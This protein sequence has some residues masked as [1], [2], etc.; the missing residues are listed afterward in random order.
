MKIMINQLV[1]N[2]APVVLLR[3]CMRNWLIVIDK[4]NIALK[5]SFKWIKKI[6]YKQAGL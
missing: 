2:Y 1:Q 6:I 5:V 3:F 4:L